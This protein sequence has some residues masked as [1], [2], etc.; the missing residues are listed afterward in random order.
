MYAK[1]IAILYAQE[2]KISNT[3]KHIFIVILSA[4]I[5]LIL[6][7]YIFINSNTFYRWTNNW[8]I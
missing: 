5:K 3:L 1:I 4:R 2:M 7:E 6:H 8:L